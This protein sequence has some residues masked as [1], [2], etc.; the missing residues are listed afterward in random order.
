[1]MLSAGYL[2]RLQI[3]YDII[4][5]KRRNG[6]AIAAIPRRFEQAA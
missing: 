3:S 5:A 4:E 6:E 2:L 1:M